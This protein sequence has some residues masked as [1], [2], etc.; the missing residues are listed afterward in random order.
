VKIS[1]ILDQ[2]ELG[3]IALP[4]FQRGYVWNRDQ[5]RGLML[6]LYKSFPVGSLLVWETKTEQ[7]DT[8]GDGP[9]SKGTVKI[10]LDGQQRMTTLY[11]II[12]GEPPK[13]FDGNE[14]TLKGLYFH[15]GDEV[16]EFYMQTKMKNDPLWIN[17]TDLMQKGSGKF[18]SS[19]MKEF[20]SEKPERLQEFID[21]LTRLDNI[22]NR[23]IYIDQISGEDKTV[24]LVVDVFNRLNSGGTKLSKGDLALAK[25]CASWPDARNEMKKELTRWLNSGYRF[26]LEWMLRNINALL[27]GE[28]LFSALKDI[29]IDQFQGGLKKATKAVDNLLNIIRSRLGLD[30]DRVLG[31][32]YSFPVMARY[33]ANNDHMQ[34]AHKDRDKLLYWYIHTFLWGRYAGSTETFIKQDLAA[35]EESGSPLDGLINLLRKSRGDLKVMPQDFAGWGVGSRF[36]PLL[37]MMT[38]VC[39]AKD[40]GSGDDLASYSLGMMN[41]LELHH[42]FPKSYLYENDFKKSEVNALAN[43]TFLTKETNLAVSDTPPHEYFPGYL[44]RHPGAVASHWIPTDPKLWKLENYREFLKERQRLMTDA[45]NQFLD[46]LLG[47]SMPEKKIAQFEGKVPEDIVGGIETMEEMKIIKDCFKWVVAQGL[48]AGEIEYELCDPESGEPIASLDLAWPD[49]LQEGLSQPVA[50]ILNEGAEAEA[51]LNE[52]GY[53]FFTKVEDFKKYVQKEILS[54]V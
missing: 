5:V 15:I 48:P 18:I 43:F 8:R 29:E 21:R 6:S 9:V 19:L 23:E 26:K 24:D 35:L 22:K 47:G 7:I 2:I 37:Y 45:A 1:T 51:V 34:L 4:E 50:I 36:Y 31:S 10:L 28:A 54:A 33:L 52:H 53:K 30:H 13:F 49:G 32:R 41:S 42:I 40:W 44:K 25:I 27:T 16:F 39:G 12:K 3:S 11:G 46:K 38:R 14:K 17:V 20:S